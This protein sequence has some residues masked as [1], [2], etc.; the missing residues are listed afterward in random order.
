MRAVRHPTAGKV[1]TLD[2]ALKALTLGGPGHIDNVTDLEQR[3]TGNLIANIELVDAI[4]TEFAKGRKR[5]LAGLL[6]MPHLRLTGPVGCLLTKTD[7]DSI[8]AISSNGLFLQDHTGACLDDRHRHPPSVGGKDLGHAQFF[9]HNSLY[10][11][12]TLKYESLKA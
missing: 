11:R 8:V 3:A 2:H 10:H 9:T 12:S 5:S 7:L 1:P 4:S 6:E